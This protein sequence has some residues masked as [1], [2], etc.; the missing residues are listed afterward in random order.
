[1]TIKEFYEK[2]GGDYDEVL[3]RLFSEALIKKFLIKF[4]TDKSYQTFFEEIEKQNIEEAF[5]AAHTLKGVSLSLGFK[6]L[7]DCSGVLCEMLR[8]GLPPSAPL[9]Q[10]LET[11]YGF[12][13]AAIRALENN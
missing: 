12:V 2:I 9:L 5:R 8:Q 13:L 3:G 10:Q 6:R 1:M 4:L 7:G 11:E